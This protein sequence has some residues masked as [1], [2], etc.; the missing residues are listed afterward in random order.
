VYICIY[1]RSLWSYG[2]FPLK[3]RADTSKNSERCVVFHGEVTRRVSNYAPPNG[4]KKI[5]VKQ[6]YTFV[7][8]F[9]ESCNYLVSTANW[10]GACILPRLNS[11]TF[12]KFV[13]R[14]FHATY[15]RRST[16][17]WEVTPLYNT[18]VDY[19][20]RSHSHPRRQKWSSRHL[21]N[22]MPPPADRSLSLSLSRFLSRFALLLVCTSA[23]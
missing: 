11:I 4:F 16:L 21:S 19:I 13:I 1:T 22:S 14:S 5:D 18:T 20:G 17:I 9:A 3:A 6:I 8:I 23:M 15:D 7:A 10:R 2:H 12:S